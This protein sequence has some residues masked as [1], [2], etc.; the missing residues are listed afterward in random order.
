MR[1]AP[2]ARKGR[3]N[4][5]VDG[6]E[7]LVYFLHVLRHIWLDAQKLPSPPAALARGCTTLVDSFA[8]RR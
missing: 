3:R 6:V 8:S 7:K 2:S 4:L 5:T 1:T